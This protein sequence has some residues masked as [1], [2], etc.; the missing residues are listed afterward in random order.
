MGCSPDSACGR[1]TGTEVI[2]IVT[3]YRSTIVRTVHRSHRR[4]LDC[5]CNSI[6]YTVLTLI[7]NII[8][9]GLVIID[10]IKLNM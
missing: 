5:V 10:E 7:T 3:Y 2:Y 9:D 6:V 1:S 8:Y 4:R